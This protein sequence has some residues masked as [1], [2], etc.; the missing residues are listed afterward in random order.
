M[1]VLWA[2]RRTMYC[3]SACFIALCKA[4]GAEGSSPARAGICGGSVAGSPATRSVSSPS[5][6]SMW[7]QPG[8][9]RSLA[10]S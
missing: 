3:L 5:L 7:N 4:N 6:S 1:T 8:L 10:A 9:Q 2:S